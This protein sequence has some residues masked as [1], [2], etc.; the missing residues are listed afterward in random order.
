L[1]NWSLVATSQLR[2]PSSRLPS[3]A[4][5]LAA[6][7]AVRTASSERPARFI[8]GMRRRTRTAGA[9]PPPMST[10]PTPR[11]CEMRC[12]S[13]VEATSYNWARPYCSE[14]SDSTMIGWSAGLTLR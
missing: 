3:G 13:K 2:S 4:W 8:S 9:A 6:A 7:I 5:V 11:T 1:R 14:V 12:A 10:L